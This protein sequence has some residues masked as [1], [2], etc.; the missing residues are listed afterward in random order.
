MYIREHVTMYLPIGHACCRLP[1]RMPFLQIV[2]SVS[3]SI[4]WRHRIAEVER[5][6]SE[7]DTG[8]ATFEAQCET[9]DTCFGCKSTRIRLDR[10]RFMA[11][12]SRGILT[13]QMRSLK[14]FARYNIS[15]EFRR[16][17]ENCINKTSSLSSNRKN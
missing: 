3:F 13:F 14:S 5:G 4:K 6:E 16:I 8:S 17:R 10:A 15:C 7:L 12:F 1:C 9:K 2:Q 11:T